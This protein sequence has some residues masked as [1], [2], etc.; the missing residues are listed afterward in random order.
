[1][2]GLDLR[3]AAKHP[4]PPIAV[5]LRRRTWMS[6]FEAELSRLGVP[7]VVAS[8]VGFWARPEVVDLVNALHALA[9]GDPISVVGAL[10]SPLLC[11]SDTAIHH[12]VGGRRWLQGAPIEAFGRA[13]L[14]QGAPADL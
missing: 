5:L 3:D 6:A 9:T 8:G 7:F 2:E 14:A 10:R 11:V 1:Y 4:A 12:L 13:P